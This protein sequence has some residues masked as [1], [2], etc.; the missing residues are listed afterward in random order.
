MNNIEVIDNYLHKR[1][2]Q[3]IYDYFTGALDKGDNANSCAWTFFPGCS[4][5]GD[6]DNWFHFTQLIFASHTIL[7]P[8]FDLMRPIIQKENMS[9]IARIKA[10]CMIMTEQLKVFTNGFHCDFRGHLT[11]GIYYINSNDGYTLFENGTKVE[12]VANRFCRF[13]CNLKH[14]ATTCTNSTTRLLINFNYHSHPKDEA[15]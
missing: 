15:V 4:M 1:E 3:L 2:H 6:D 9:A 10:N 8:A 5:L 12:S 11:T 14:T 13:D 7:S